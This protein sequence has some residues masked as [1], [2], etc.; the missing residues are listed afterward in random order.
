MKI[1]LFFV[2]LCLAPLAAQAQ[3]APKKESH[4]VV[5]RIKQPEKALKF[6]VIVPAKPADVWRAFSTSAGLNA[7]VALAGLP[8]RLISLTCARAAAGL[9]TI[10][11]GQDRRW[12][13]RQ[14]P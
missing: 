6:E 8:G 14:L 7:A 1:S 10:P 5:T 2:S 13:H 12:H 4:V 9:S 3:D 11:C